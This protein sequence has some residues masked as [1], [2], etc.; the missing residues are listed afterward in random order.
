MLLAVGCGTLTYVFVHKYTIVFPSIFVGV[1]TYFI[2]D[3]FFGVYSMA[4]STMLLCACKSVLELFT[5]I[6][7]TIEALERLIINKCFIF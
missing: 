2:A 5:E 1:A 6:Q 4:T 7:F 3:L